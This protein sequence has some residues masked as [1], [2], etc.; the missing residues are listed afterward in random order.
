MCYKI[1]FLVLKMGEISLFLG[2][3]FLLSGL[4]KPDSFEHFVDL[5]ERCANIADSLNIWNLNGQLSIEN[6]VF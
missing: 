4:I 5:F 6:A 1:A 2:I 3:G